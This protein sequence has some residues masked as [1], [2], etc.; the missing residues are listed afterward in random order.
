MC[1]YII[2]MHNIYIICMHNICV[3]NIAYIIGLE[4]DGA[5]GPICVTICVRVC[6]KLLDIDA[7]YLKLHIPMIAK[8]FKT[9]AII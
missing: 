5:V 3:Y 4:L 9:K 8:Y 6:I 1:I 2:C 7:C